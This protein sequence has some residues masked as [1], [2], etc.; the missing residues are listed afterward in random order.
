MVVVERRADGRVL[1]LTP[2]AAGAWNAM[3]EAAADDGVTLQLVSA[4]RSVA[5][6]A[7]IIA[8][9]LAVGQSLEAIL[10]VNAYPGF[11]EH[12]TGNAVDVGCPGCPPLTQQ[13][14]DTEAW[15]WLV[16]NAG[17]FGYSLSYPPGNTAGIGF[18]PWHWCHRD[19]VS[20]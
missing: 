3:R 8:A 11:S 19:E 7:E 15:R 2:R 5:R 6:Q 12:H 4:Y 9:K 14:A 17:R 1:Q 18:E 16:A 20:L 13:F 10:A